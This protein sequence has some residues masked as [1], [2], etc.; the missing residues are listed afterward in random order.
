MGLPVG[1]VAGGGRDRFPTPVRTGSGAEGVLSAP[2][3]GRGTP[4]DEGIVR[5]AE[6]MDMLWPRTLRLFFAPVAS[7]AK[8]AV[9]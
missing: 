9:K 8:N 2:P 7:N 4:S 6:R 1:K 3:T 5:G